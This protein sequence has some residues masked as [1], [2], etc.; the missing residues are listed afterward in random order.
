MQLSKKDILLVEMFSRLGFGSENIS[1]KN[2]FLR[3]PRE[4]RF[5]KDMTIDHHF[6][7]G[8]L[9]CRGHSNKGR[10]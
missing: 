5:K 1:T 6:K 3:Q 8:P 10:P 2:V 9:L 7:P 4:K